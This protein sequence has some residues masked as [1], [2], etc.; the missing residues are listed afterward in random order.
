M[1]A[2]LGAAGGGRVDAG[3]GV[4]VRPTI[5]INYYLAEGLSFDISG[6]QIISPYG[7]VNSSNFN[8]GLT[9]RLSMLNS[10]Q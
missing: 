6:G 1:E 4:L 3:V 10:K 7:N 9:Y 2:N 8:I 5:G